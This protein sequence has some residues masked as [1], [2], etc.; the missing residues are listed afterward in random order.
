MSDCFVEFRVIGSINVTAKYKAMPGNGKTIRLS[1]VKCILLKALKNKMKK[2]AVILLFLLSGLKVW[3]QQADA[4]TGTW[5]LPDQKAQIRIVPKGEGYAGKLTNATVTIRNSISLGLPTGWLGIYIL[6]DIRYV[7]G[8]RWEGMIYNPQD[9]KTYSCKLRLEN[10]S[11]LR[12]RGYKGVP[13]LGKT[14]YLSKVN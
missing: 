10:D 1:T 14:L 12:V 9:Q 8:N 7:K 11:T 3:A 2:L 5:Q 4:I 6:R 13:L